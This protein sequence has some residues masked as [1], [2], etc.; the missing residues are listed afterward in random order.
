LLVNAAQ[1]IPDGNTEKNEVRIATRRLAEDRVEVTVSDT[2]VGIEP[3]VLDRIFEPFFTTKATGGTGL[4][5]SICH[6]IV[7]GLGGSIDAEGRA[8]GGTC[9]RVVLPCESRR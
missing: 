9:F 1:S 6:S 3:A 4:G 7:T 8:G 2:G 5:L